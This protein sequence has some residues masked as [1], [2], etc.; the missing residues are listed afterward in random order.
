MVG[1]TFPF[2]YAASPAVVN[3]GSAG[4]YAILA[5]SAVSDVPTS[6]ITGNV[7][8][9]PAAGTFITGL[10]CPEV[11]GNI[12][13]ASGG[14]PA[15]CSIVDPTDLTPQILAM[16][17]AY[18]DA[19]TRVCGNS[20][21]TTDLSGLTFTTGVWCWTSGAT[22]SGSFTVS[23]SST[24]VFIFQIP[25]TFTVASGIH[26][27]LLGG[28]SY[29][30]IFWA[31][32]GATQIGTTAAMQGIILDATQIQFLTGASLVGRAM[33]QTQVTLQSNTISAP[34]VVVIT[35]PEFPVGLLVLAVPILAVYLF[36]RGRAGSLSARI[37]QA[38]TWALPS[39]QLLSCR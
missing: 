36:M 32:G 20:E 13:E 39:L 5:K 25:G 15:P 27:T 34:P 21:G 31:V 6:I 14:G 3:L 35:V 24:D 33:A 18:T 22:A 9:S 29:S 37:R 4:T 17:A 38:D 8:L 28:A 2:V 12:Y 7:G 16:Q 11:T 1:G 23:G 19:S 10:T 30:N 26:I